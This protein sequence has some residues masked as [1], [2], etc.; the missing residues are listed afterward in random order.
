MSLIYVRSFLNFRYF[1]ALHLY[2]SSRVGS[3]MLKLELDQ[4]AAQFLLH[5][6]LQCSPYWQ[7]SVLAYCCICLKT[8][9]RSRRLR[10][11]RLGCFSILHVWLFQRRSLPRRR[12]SIQLCIEYN[13]LRSSLTDAV[14]RTGSST[15]LKDISHWA[16]SSSEAAA[17]SVEPGTAEDVGEIVRSLILQGL[18]HPFTHDNP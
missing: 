15:Y 10:V 8:Q 9:G 12:F 11:S 13:V 3:R 18:V 17:C 1:R 6:D 4:C 7:S 2:L 14:P 5:P 16:S